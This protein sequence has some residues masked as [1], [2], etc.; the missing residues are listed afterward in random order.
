VENYTIITGNANRVAEDIHSRMPV[1]IDPAD[2]DRWLT[3]QEPPA[4]L[5]KPYPAA[6]MVAYPVS[7]AV[8]SPA[9]DESSL[10]EPLTA[11]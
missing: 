10:L 4:D 11:L 8:N 2:F 7:K 1:I 9:L 3:A 5:L 6:G